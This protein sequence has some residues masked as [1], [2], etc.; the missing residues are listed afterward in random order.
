MARLQITTDCEFFFR[1]LFFPKHAWH[2]FSASKW[3]KKYLR[4][5]LEQI[6]AFTSQ[7][8]CNTVHR[9]EEYQEH[10]ARTKGLIWGSQKPDPTFL[11]QYA[12]EN[13]ILYVF[14]STSVSEFSNRFSFK[15]A[16]FTRWPIWMMFV[17]WEQKTRTR[18]LCTCLFTTQ[19]FSWDGQIKKIFQADCIHH[20]Y[21]HIMQNS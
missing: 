21:V 15:A 14:Y 4:P 5:I 1:A 20:L 2:T 8:S 12:R 3:I 11:V 18:S 10:S 13:I 17:R 19:H 7:H 6:V 9:M 16:E